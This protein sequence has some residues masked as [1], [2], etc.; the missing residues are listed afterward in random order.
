MVKETAHTLKHTKKK[1]VFHESPREES[2]RQRSRLPL[3]A[4]AGKSLSNAEAEIV[5]RHGV[6]PEGHGQIVI[7]RELKARGRQKLQGVNRERHRGE[8][9]R[10]MQSKS[11]ERWRT[12]RDRT[13]RETR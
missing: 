9:I 4:R 10:E 13:E 3:S 12:L 1:K 5:R 11:S 6:D 8:R 7:R 2:E